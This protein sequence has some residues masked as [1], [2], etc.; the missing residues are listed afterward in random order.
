M[1]RSARPFNARKVGTIGPGDK[2]RNGAWAGGEF[3]SSV[4]AT[5]KEATQPYPNFRFSNPG[6][7]QPSVT[8][9]A[10]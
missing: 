2:H 1:R 10:T 8:A 5:I 7:H 3:D 9:R 6:R 4:Y